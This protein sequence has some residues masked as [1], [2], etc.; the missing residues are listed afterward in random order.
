MELMAVCP[1][2]GAVHEDLAAKEAQNTKLAKENV[3]LRRA[4]ADQ[5]R[6]GPR[7]DEIREV[8][9]H[10]V[11][12]LGKRHDTVLGDARTKAVKARLNEGFTVDRLKK[13]IDGCKL[14]DWAM[15]RLKKTRGQTFNDLAKHICASDETVER[16]EE[17]VDKR[18]QDL[19]VREGDA[20]RRVLD[21]LEQRDLKVKRSDNGWEAQCPAHD[22]R[23]PSM[24]IGL[25]HDRVLL[26]CQR[27]CSV[28]EICDR[29]GLPTAALFD[30]WKDAVPPAPRQVD[31]KR[32]LEELPT[33]QEL[34]RWHTAL[35]ANDRAMG[36]L[37]RRKGWSVKTLQLFGIGVHAGRLVFP[38]RGPGGELVTLARYRLN[39]KNG[40][41]K[42]LGFPGRKRDLF[43]APERFPD[44]DWLW[45][46][47]GEPDA[48]SAAELGLYGVGLPGAGPASQG[49]LEEWAPRFEGRRVVVCLDCDDEGRACARRAFDALAGAA[50]EVRLIDLDPS[51]R[52]GFDL[53]D[54]LVRGGLEVARHSVFDLFADSELEVAA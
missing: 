39:R 46:V 37:L 30:D 26:H 42:M 4:L 5:H 8:F 6:S 20:A 47:E 16:F 17:M 41:P 1:T 18:R 28:E 3:G 45:L 44:D 33:E 2:C 14:D 7:M 35:I 19:D 11:E 49:R 50:A 43:P 21:R 24:S 22:D 10:W 48:V 51:K 31:R 27:G 32:E 12:T 36:E 52:D 54:L 40:E 13:A 23:N 34:S 29:L 53:G 15:G 25:N 38:V 9:E